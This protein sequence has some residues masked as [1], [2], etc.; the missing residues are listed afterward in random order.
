[1]GVTGGGG[2]GGGGASAPR[3]PPPPPTSSVSLPPPPIPFLR[4]GLPAHAHLQILPAPACRAE[5]LRPPDAD[6]AP[7]AAAHRQATGRP[8]L[9]GGL[10]YTAV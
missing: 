3:P 8:S 7:A 10:V 4:A 6:A 5:T 2:G 1:V 9:H